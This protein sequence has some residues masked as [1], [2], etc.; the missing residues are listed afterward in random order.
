MVGAFGLMKPFSLKKTAVRPLILAAALAAAFSAEAF[1]AGWTEDGDGS[2]RYQRADG[3][4]AEGCWEWIDT[5]G[6]GQEEAY[7]FSTEGVLYIGTVTPDGYTVNASGQWTE[8]GVV[9][10]QPAAAAAAPG[11][12]EAAIAGPGETKAPEPEAE[13]TEAAE[14][15]AAGSAAPAGTGAGG[16]TAAETVSAAALDPAQVDAGQI[17]DYFKDSVF[18]GDSVM[19]GYRNY[20][21]RVN[22]AAV[23][24]MK[25]LVAGS[26]GAH[27]ALQPVGG[28]SLHPLY[29]GKQHPVWESVQLMGA[30]KV[31]IDFGLNDLAVGDDTVE[32]FDT[33]NSY[34]NEL[35]PDAGINVIS[36]TYVAAGAGKRKLN[37]TNIRA[38]NA[39][40]QALCAERGWGFVNIAD[41]LADSNG[42]L[43][44]RYCS[45]NY[46]HE[47]YEAYAVW[48]EVLK[49]FAAAEIAA[50]RS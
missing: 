35:S 16:Q 10:T 44:A 13:E 7:C 19:M 12:T 43:A 15:E 3:T 2:H 31:F 6:D 21:M 36:M 41:A 37:N 42:D 20:S 9:K 45:D 5:D 38:F 39:R 17:A 33:V 34:I 25:F 50:G 32:C 30:K 49:Q 26:Y 23:G 29:Q 40:M 24:N 8:N 47:T 1:A 4:Y 46:V 18:I 14:A 11:E 48:T 28:G 22:D 27:E